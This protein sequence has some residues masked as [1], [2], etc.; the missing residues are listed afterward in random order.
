MRKVGDLEIR[1]M[2]SGSRRLDPTLS[3]R[4]PSA[5]LATGP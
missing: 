2:P 1:M 5:G 3:P 4:L